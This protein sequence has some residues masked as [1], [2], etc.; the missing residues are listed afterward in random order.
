MSFLGASVGTKEDFVQRPYISLQTY[1]KV[2]P[3]W[4]NGKESYFRQELGTGKEESKEEK[5]THGLLLQSDKR[6]KSKIMV[7]FCW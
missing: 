5:E 3:Y 7:D 6:K 2:I 1:W 4:P